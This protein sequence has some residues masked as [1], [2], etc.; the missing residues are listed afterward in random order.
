MPTQI[1]KKIVAYSVMANEI[2]PSQSLHEKLPRPEVLNGTTYKLKTPL[3]EHGMYVTINNITLNI[4]TPDEIT[5]PFEIF[6]NSKAMEHF[7]WIVALTRIIS[8]TFRKGGDVVFLLEELQSVFDP[9]G[10][11][12]NKGKYVPS[13]VAEIG[14]IIEQH[15]TQLGMYKRDT[16]LALAAQAMIEE[17]QVKP[18]GE[19][20]SQCGDVGLVLMD[21]CLTCVSCGYSKCG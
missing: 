15:L 3:S 5:R 7:Q 1:T 21:G 10:G 12:F 6:I 13:L 2:N 9:K 8:A 18:P 17:K 11:Y 20:C 16:S 4:G 19:L 14:N